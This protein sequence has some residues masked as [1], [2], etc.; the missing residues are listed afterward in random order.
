MMDIRQKAVEMAVDLTAWRRYLHANPELS[1]NETETA[2]Y[3]RKYLTELGIPFTTPSGNSTVGVIRGRKPGKTVAIRADIDALPIIEE[4]DLDFKSGRPGA[5]HA[6]GHD[7]H[8]AILMGVARLFAAN[9]DFPGTIKLLFQEA[10]E[11]VPGGAKPLVESGAIDDVDHVIGLHLMSD[12]PTGQA[13]IIAGPMMASA[14][15]VDV[16]IIGKGGHGAMPHQTVDAVVVASNFVMNLQTVVARKVDPLSPA[17]ISVGSIQS[18]FTHNVIAQTAELKATVRTFDDQTRQLIYREFERTLAATCDIY[19]ATYEYNYGWGYATLVN[20]PYET[21][22]FQEVVR[23]T[24]GEDALIDQKP[25]MGGE[26]FAAYL[27]AKPGAFL[28]LGCRSEA[29]GAVWPHH[30]PRFTIDEAA[31]PYGV[32]V[33]ARTALK[34][35]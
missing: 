25:T 1:F 18:G 21:A 13:G 28:F 2:G 19:G 23:E 17:V 12:I 15:F 20:H 32:E 14:D 5:M 9:P 35:L 27:L 26:D 7:G 30:H 4:T 31:L 33:L 16:K 11:K 10:E 29:A 22:V 3:I 8:T 34:L 6:C 24:L